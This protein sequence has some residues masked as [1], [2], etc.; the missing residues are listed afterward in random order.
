MLSQLMVS[1]LA[2]TIL[3]ITNLVT[4]PTRS[5]KQLAVLIFPAIFFIANVTV[6]LLALKLV[7]IPM[8]SAFRRLSVLSVMLLEYLVLGK[9]A[10][11]K[12]IITVFIMVLGSCIAGLGDLS[13]D[14]LGYCL[15]LINNF[16]TAAN[17]VSI[18]KATSIVSL[19]A[20]PLFYYI[21]LIALPIVFL[22]SI[23]TGEVFVAIDQISTREDL[24][25]PAF[26]AALSLSA[27]SAFLIN[28]FTNMCT[29]LT[30]PLTTAITGQ[31]KNVLQT[32]LG[33]FAF[34]YIVTPLNL[35]GLAVALGGSLMFAR[36]KYVDA[37]R[38]KLLRKEQLPIS[39]ST[40]S[41][42]T[43]YAEEKEESESLPAL[44]RPSR[45]APL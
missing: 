24:Q 16:I 31:M 45:M 27:A 17:L 6:G 1:V 25:T 29:Q 23:V 35:V 21:S 3:R 38:A 36:Y 7:N 44:L 15:V 30:S 4:I 9:T 26:M 18:K 2:I 37:Q 32:L 11:K 34:G 13:F 39:N 14:P 43:S 40:T 8:F 33:I 22:L 5:I 20:L 12:I 19:E 41:T 10:S 28:F 42:A